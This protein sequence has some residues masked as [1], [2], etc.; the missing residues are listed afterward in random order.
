MRG[1]LCLGYL[2]ALLVGTAAAATPYAWRLPRG[3]PEPAVPA[4]NPMSAEKVAL[5]ERLFADPRLSMTGQYSCQSCHAPQ[6]A[7]TDGRARSVGA[8]GGEM[9]L[10]APTLLNAAYSPSLGWNDDGVTSLEQQMRG[11]LFNQHPPELGLAGREATVEQ[12]LVGD[13]GLAGEFAMAFPGEVPAV[14]LDNVIR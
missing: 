10:N 5:G 8:T 6:H 13:A 11:P 7:F 2:L 4:N 1:R 12:L 3:F 14:T 9:R